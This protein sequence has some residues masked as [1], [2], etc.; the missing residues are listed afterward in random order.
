MRNNMR[1]YGKWMFER[2]DIA[3]LFKLVENGMFKLGEAGGLEV[4]GVFPLEQWKEAWDLAAEKALFGQQAL[5][6]P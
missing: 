4:T 3:D 2:S 5:I 1:I 6:K